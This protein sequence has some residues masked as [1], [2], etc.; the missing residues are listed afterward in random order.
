MTAK[1]LLINGVNL[2]LLGV[3]E[4]EIYG[5]TTLQDIESDCL[6][7]AN[8]LNITLK[9][10]QSNHEGEIVNCI[11]QAI[12]SKIDGI[13]INPG[14]YSH[15]SIAI[16]DALSAFSGIIIEVHL[17]NIHAREAFRHHSYVSRH[18]KG[19]ICGLGAEGYIYALD[20][21]AK[22]LLTTG[23]YIIET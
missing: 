19:V 20:A 12:H 17:S 6:K 18:A 15:T 11:H 13:I 9:C 10:F 4:P 5:S 3:R 8:S 1:V 14:A 22:N 7:K 23:D 21:I 16:M 2:N